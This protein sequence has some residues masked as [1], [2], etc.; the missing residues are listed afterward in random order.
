MFGV[1]AA[2]Y[3]GFTGLGVDSCVAGDG[4]EDDWDGYWLYPRTYQ[5]ARA[6]P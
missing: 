3:Q 2:M 6:L 4:L 5:V 1:F